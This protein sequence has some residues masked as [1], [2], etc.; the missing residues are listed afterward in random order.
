MEETA[1]KF[2]QR[3]GFYGRIRKVS[4]TEALFKL[5]FGVNMAD[6]IGPYVGYNK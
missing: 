4:D 3:N 2:E 5:L 1:K 6:S